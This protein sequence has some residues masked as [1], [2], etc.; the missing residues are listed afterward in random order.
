M[1][2]SEK[3]LNRTLRGET[4]YK[5]FDFMQ[6]IAIARGLKTLIQNAYD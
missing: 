6:A 1:V 5:I 4:V 2:S 3:I